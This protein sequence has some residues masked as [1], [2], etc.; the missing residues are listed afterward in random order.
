MKKSPQVLI[1]DASAG[2]GKTYCLAK[3]YLGLLLK[4]DA[5]PRQ[6]EQILAITFTNKAC[7]EMKERI[8]DFLKEIALDEFPDALQEK[9]ILS[10]LELGKQ[11]ARTKAARLM[12]YIITNYNF[13]QVKT[14]DSFINMILLGCAYQLGLSANFEIRDDRDDYLTLSLDDCI[15]RANRDKGMRR[16]FDDFLQQY[17]YLEGKNSWFPKKDILSILSSMLYHANA[18]GSFFSKFDLAGTNLY[19]EKQGLLK[20]YQKLLKDA[21]DGLN[22]T[23]RNSLAKFV[24]DN[25]ELFDFEEI[26]RRENFL[27][28]DIPMKKGEP[29]PA[30][31]KKLWDEIRSRITE[32]SEKEARAY[33]NCYI[34]I[35]ELVYAAFRNYAR[36]DDVLFLEELNQQANSLIRENGVTVPE[37]YYHLATRLRHYLI[38]EFQDTSLLQW[39]NL[40]PMVEEAISTGGTLFYVGDKKQAIF[41][42]RGGEVALFEKI[43]RDFRQYGSSEFL[44]QN[45]RSA[46]EIVEFNNAIF[47]PANLRRFLNEQQEAVKDD[48]K[49]FS[50]EDM[51]E[52]LEVFSGPAQECSDS[53]RHGVVRVEMVACPGL[54]ERDERI[55]EKTLALLDA[56]TETDRFAKKEITILGRGNKDVERISTWLIG[57]NIPVESEKTLNIKNNKFIKELLALL[58]FLNSPIDNLSFAAFI[59]GDIFLKA[60]KL[61]KQKMEEFLFGLRQKLSGEEGFYIYREFRRNYPELWAQFLEESFREVGYI[62]LYE[63][64]VDS[65]NRLQAFENFPDQQ[66][67]FM[68]FLQVITDSEEEHP[69]IA[70]FLDYFEEIAET[71]L[72]VNS[73]GADAVRVMTIHKAKGLGFEVV[74]IPFLYLDI[75]ELGSQAKKRKVSYVVEEEKDSLSLL[76]LDKKYA[77]LS[78]QI[79]SKYREEY[80]KEFIDEL[81]VIYVALTR[82]KSELYAFLPHGI[83]AANNVARF[84]LPQGTIQLGEPTTFRKPAKKESS[85]LPI[86]ASQYW[87]W[88][89]FLKEEFSEQTLLEKRENLLAGKVVHEILAAVG[90][91]AKDDREKSLQ[92]GLSR[93][94]DLFP[95]ANG[96][97]EH[98]NMARKVLEAKEL[99]PFFYLTDVEVYQEKEVVDNQGRTKRIDRL[100]IG[101][102]EAWVVDYKTR[103][104][105]Q[106]DYRQQIETYKAII[107]ELYP[108]LIVRGFI[109]YL[110]ELRAEEVDG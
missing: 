48:L 85:T 30:G 101:K 91:L 8:L 29:V 78:P 77:R 82:P 104:E 12:D 15:E 41:R 24:D 95:L 108:R 106:L 33:F 32:L 110:D 17:I 13:F 20:F 54:A 71:K 42:F 1:V 37:L 76:R 31:L 35:F 53:E 47:S 21:P 2:S 88:N 74:I 67:F 69:G 81:N 109:I 25:P 11:E 3:Y 46:K 49:Y 27:K 28:A 45:F 5:R 98:E 66:G 103:Q 4:K 18:Y 65:L 55:K 51:D 22:G 44:K 14:I 89:E 96:F 97:S 10:G 90:N 84:L 83:K 16:I 102:K 87:K 62:G 64:L 9:D 52:I 60:A 94:K 68:H 73:S 56:L 79:L 61:D 93:A 105:P 40:F 70:D 7:R 26:S 58:R 72:F 36:K 99:R 57:K 86:K 63:L 100:I 43:R 59:L 92:E 19:Q 38:D 34:A 75:N 6:I 80:R 50:P 107:K 39:L 23:F